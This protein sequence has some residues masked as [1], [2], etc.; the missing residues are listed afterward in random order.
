MELDEK[1]GGEI[2]ELDEKKY[3]RFSKHFV[4]KTVLKF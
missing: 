3:Q 1:K 4:M 2:M